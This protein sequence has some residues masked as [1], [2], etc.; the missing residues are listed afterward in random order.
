MERADKPRGPAQPLLYGS[1][2]WE[3]VLPGSMGR[4]MRL[5]VALVWDCPLVT[6]VQSPAEPGRLGACSMGKVAGADGQERITVPLV[7]VIESLAS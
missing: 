1:S 2:N 6:E 3:R 4:T 7:R 5:S